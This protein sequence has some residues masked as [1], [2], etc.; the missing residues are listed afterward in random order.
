MYLERF[1]SAARGPLRHQIMPIYFAPDQIE[2]AVRLGLP[3]RAAGALARFEPWATAARH[4]WAE[5]VL[6]RCHALLADDDA[7]AERHWRLATDAHADANRP[8]ERARTDLL[9]GEWLRRARRKNEARTRL[10]G[11]LETFDRAGARPWS[12]RARAELR[13]T[14]ETVTAGAPDLIAL[15]SP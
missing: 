13:A 5:A 1:D 14:G 9:Y 15:L 2:A 7:T 8:F 4:P 6:H 12:E 11:A 3:D 10:R